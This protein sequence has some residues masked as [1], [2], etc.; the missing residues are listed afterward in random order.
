MA[1]VRET[2]ADH[3]LDALGHRKSRRCDARLGLLARAADHTRL[4]DVAQHLHDE[5][6]VALGP[7]ID[8]PA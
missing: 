5:E 6:R 4:R 3:A 1:E 8:H 2:L 7:L